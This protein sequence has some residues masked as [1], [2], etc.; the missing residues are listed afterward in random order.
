MRRARIDDRGFAALRAHLARTRALY[1]ARATGDTDG[2]GGATA[3]RRADP[4]RP[5]DWDAALPLDGAK[6]FFFPQSE[7]LLTWNDGELRAA[8]VAAP[9]I[10]L[11][12]LRACDATALAYQDRFFARDAAYRARRAAALVVAIDCLAWCGGGFCA[13][14]DAGP[15]A[16]EGFD[17]ALTRLAPDAIVVTVG[18]AAG[19]RLLA[20]AGVDA[21]PASPDDERAHARAADAARASFP[22]EPALAAAIARVAGEPGARPVAD[23]E[24]QRLGP[25]C[26]ACTGCTSLCPT[27]SCFTIE[28]ERTPGARDAGVRQRLWDSCLLEG[29]Q[30]EA[31]GHDPVPRPGDRVRRF[32]THKL[33]RTYA[34]RLGRAGCVGC[35]RCDVTCPGSIGARGVL[36][37]LGA[38][39]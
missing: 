27:C 13:T 15:F 23:D 39:S 18:T 20:E 16:R 29:F 5:F 6:R 3:W 26:F 7:T 22:P 11:L 17:L 19:E 4:S 8:P 1:E 10:A 36:G 33:E 37:R 31:S 34:E 14:V 9:A 21:T 32:W 35:G 24:W 28:D 2:A 30:R 12:G 38:R 25:L